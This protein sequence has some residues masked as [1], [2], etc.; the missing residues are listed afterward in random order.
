MV[1][2][3]F[4]TV[5]HQTFP[6][7]Y[8]SVF[9]C[10]VTVQCRP[11]TVSAFGGQRPVFGITPGCHKRGYCVAQHS[12]TEFGLKTHTHTH[13]H[14]HKYLEFHRF[15]IVH[16]TRGVQRG[17]AKVSAFVSEYFFLISVKSVSVWRYEPPSSRCDNTKSCSCLLV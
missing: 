6:R 14:T 13:T 3:P 10:Q 12:R 8:K 9:I 15:G 4:F 11:Q 1:Y 5:I 17:L 7:I 2:V 16:L